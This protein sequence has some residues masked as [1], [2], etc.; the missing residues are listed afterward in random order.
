ML[1]TP[2]TTANARLILLLQRL[3]LSNG[4]IYRLAKVLSM[5]CFLVG[6]LPLQEMTFYG[7]TY[8]LVPW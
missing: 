5:T 6:N 4:S 1:D 7:K 2:Y 8:L 3:M